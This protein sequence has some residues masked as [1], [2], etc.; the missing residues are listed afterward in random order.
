MV[1]ESHDPPC[2]SGRATGWLVVALV[3][4]LLSIAG[5]AI[6]ASHG[7]EPLP[8]LLEELLSWVLGPGTTVWWLTLG[9][10]FQT[11][12][13]SGRGYAVTIV[14]NAGCWWVVV[15]LARG[16]VERALRVGRPKR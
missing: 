5:V 16:I 6:E 13:R 1:T 8:P 7:T 15:V 12:P 9:G 3:V 14:A 2:R 11:F 10:P 4:V